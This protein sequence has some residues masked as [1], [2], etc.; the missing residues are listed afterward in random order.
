MNNL[1]KNWVRVLISLLAGG[2]TTEIIHISTGD[3]D[4]PETT[5]F[6]LLYALIIYIILTI[7]MKFNSVDNNC[8]QNKM[9]TRNNHKRG[10]IEKPNE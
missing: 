6:T 4:R 2:M 5:N 1:K 9:E 8:Q 10:E 3:P 7:I